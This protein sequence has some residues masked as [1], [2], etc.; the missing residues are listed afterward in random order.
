MTRA[1]ASAKYDECT[2]LVSFRQ[3]ST[4]SYPRL[5]FPQISR[6][7]LA[8]IPDTPMW[9]SVFYSR[10]LDFGVFVPSRHRFCLPNGA[11]FRP[12]HEL[13]PEVP[14]NHPANTRARSASAFDRARAPLT[15]PNPLLVRVSNKIPAIGT[16]T[17]VRVIPI[18]SFPV[19]PFDVRLIIFF[20]F[21]FFMRIVL[22]VVPN[23][24]RIR[25]CIRGGTC[26]TSSAAITHCSTPA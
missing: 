16:E 5:S 14:R 15:A 24:P 25:R 20:C 8:N 17:P 1:Q 7:L 4:Q 3:P 2:I 18:R 21:A 12:T 26:W 11:L 23:N 22:F 10:N 13:P 6:V 19:L 9:S